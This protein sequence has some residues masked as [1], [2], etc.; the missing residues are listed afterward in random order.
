MISGTSMTGPAALCPDLLDQRLKA[1]ADREDESYAAAQHG[2]DGEYYIQDLGDHSCVGKI[3]DGPE[4][5]DLLFQHV[6]HA[7][8]ED[9]GEDHGAD[10]AEGSCH[11][12]FCNNVFSGTDDSFGS[13]NTGF[14]SVHE[15]HDDR[16]VNLILQDSAYTFDEV[17]RLSEPSADLTNVRRISLRSLA[18]EE[19][20]TIDKISDLYPRILSM[21]KEYEIS[22]CITMHLQQM[23][24]CYYMASHGF[25]CTFLRSSTLQTVKDTG[26]LKFY[27]I[28]SPR[29]FR[30]SRL[31]YKKGGY[32]TR[33]M[34]ALLDWLEDK[35]KEASLNA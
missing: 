9:Y 4:C 33:A 22:P 6:R 30:N 29:S 10:A 34:Q 15:E 12:G 35:Q 14:V 31:Y 28:D 18:Q 11:E 5:R 24:T 16:D 25:G 13:R 26:R 32:M 20:I 7:G 23:C 21:F 2:G 1:V 19:F 17:S 3:V 27:F 8:G